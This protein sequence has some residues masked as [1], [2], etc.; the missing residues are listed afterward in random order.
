[1]PG[2]G[3]PTR[4]LTYY[5]HH[6]EDFSSIANPPVWATWYPAWYVKCTVSSTRPRFSNEALRKEDHWGSGRKGVAHKK[7]HKSFRPCLPW[8]APIIPKK[9]LSS[10]S[11]HQLNKTTARL[12]Y[13]T[14]NLFAADIKASE[15][16]AQVNPKNSKSVKPFN[17]PSIS[18]VSLFTCA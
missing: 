14:L 1:M 16:F 6:I 4:L 15:R 9:K 2:L 17:Y 8:L 11:S 13:R 10:K 7:A 3:V 5:F 12:D 18:P